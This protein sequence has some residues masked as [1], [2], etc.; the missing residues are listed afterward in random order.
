MKNRIKAKAWCRKSK[1]YSNGRY[2][3]CFNP[4]YHPYT[5]AEKLYFAS[6]EVVRHINRTIKKIVHHLFFRNRQNKV[7]IHYLTLN[8]LV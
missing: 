5:V 1:L 6:A 8:K 4:D 2:G 7:G 3:A